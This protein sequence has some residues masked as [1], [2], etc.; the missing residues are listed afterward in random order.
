MAIRKEIFFEA[1]VP[2]FW[3]DALTD[4]L[5]LSAAVHA[6]GL[7]IAW[8]PGALTPCGEH[9]TAAAFFPWIRRQMSIMRLYAPRLWWP[10][11]VAHIFYCG[12]MAASVI[13][14]DPRRSSC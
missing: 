4:D 14:S 5:T 13:A 7:T 11:L 8:A 1:R 12:G 6:A 9:T 2:E 3:Q 10:A